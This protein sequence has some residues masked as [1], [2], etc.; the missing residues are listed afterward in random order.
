MDL[1]NCT[2]AGRL[3][4]DPE[5]TK[6]PTGKDKA[7]FTIMVNKSKNG[8]HGKASPVRCIV[9]GESALNLE[10][11]ASK[12]RLVCVIGRHEMREYTTNDGQQKEIWELAVRDWYLMDRPTEKPDSAPTQDQPYDPFE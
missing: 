5:V 3:A 4:R 11:Y 7:T 10:Q 1:N 2:F 12:G 8:N 6:T 9:W